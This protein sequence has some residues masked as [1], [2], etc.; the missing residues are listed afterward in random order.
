MTTTA[1]AAN[2]EFHSS[3]S[4]PNNSFLSRQR[5][6]SFKKAGSALRLIGTSPAGE[7]A[8]QASEKYEDHSELNEHHMET[9]RTAPAGGSTNSPTGSS[10]NLNPNGHVIVRGAR[11]PSAARASPTRTVKIVPMKKVLAEDKKKTYESAYKAVKK[12]PW[13]IID[14]RKG[15]WRRPMVMWDITTTLALVYT[16]FLTP[17]EVA[18]LDP[19]KTWAAAVVDPLFL[20]NRV[21]DLMYARARPLSARSQFFYFNVAHAFLFAP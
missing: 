13:Y 10:S 14:P 3:T 19:P 2:E 17:Y 6:S 9:H 15:R 1:V 5:R 4:S 16:A 20:I 21:I 18:F 8:R 11:A 7:R 12:V